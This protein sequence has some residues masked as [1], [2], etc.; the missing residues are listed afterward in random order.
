MQNLIIEKE[1]KNINNNFNSSKLTISD[2][3]EFY[4][5]RITDKS[6]YGIEYERISFDKNTKSVATYDKISKIIENFSSI[7][8]WDLIYDSGI[9]IGAKDINGSSISLEPG[10]QIEL[11]LR[12]FENLVDIQSEAEK[13]LNLLDKIANVY[14]VVFLGFGINPKNSVDQINILQKD[15]YKIMND[16]LPYCNKGELCPKMMRQTAGIQINIDYKNIADAYNKVLFFNLI[17]PF[18]SGLCANSP[19]ENNVLTNKKTNRA[20]AWLYTG[21]NRCNF[22]YKDVYKPI[23]FKQKNFLKN[24]IKQILKVPMVYIERNGE[25][26]PF[27]GKVDFLTYMNSGY[28]GYFATLDDYILHQSLCFP[29]VRLKNYIEIRNHDSSDFNVALALCAFYKG[30]C[31]CDIQELLTLFNFL[32]IDKISYY[33]E[34]VVNCGLDFKVNSK[35][36]G[37]DIVFK[38]FNIARKKLSSKERLY[39]KPFFD[40]LIHRKTKADILIDYG[41]NSFDSL[42]EFLS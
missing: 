17:M 42:L 22:F 37:W 34:L 38:L 30:L 18:M 2:I 8:N 21:E 13:I 11:S 15:R 12:P 3:E 24:Y 20:Y 19:I 25:N 5:S 4:L 1:P 6:L 41:I 23:F 10:C 39:L 16:Y 27:S 29:D 14:D 31:L 28:N 33:S 9:V 26:I 35:Y 36:D 40:I 32:K 7:L